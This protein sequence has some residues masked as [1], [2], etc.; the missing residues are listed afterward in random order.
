[1]AFDAGS[2]E[3]R[4]TIDT[5]A[6]DR[7]LDAFEA[8]VK[9]FEDADHKVKIAAA[10]DTSSLSRARQQFAQ[11]DQQISK[12]AMSRLRS[13]PQG[14]VLGALNALFS[15]HPVTGAPTAQQAARQGPPGTMVSSPGGGGPPLPGDSRISGSTSQ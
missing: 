11:L 4:L 13:S 10:L 15:P 12:D 7:S 14:S 8:R 9:A 3:A 5:S 6:G 1:M 2:I